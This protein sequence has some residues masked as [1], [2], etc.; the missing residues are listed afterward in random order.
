MKLTHIRATLLRMAVEAGG[1]LP[2]I[3]LAPPERGL[4]TRMKAD[5]LVEWD[6]RV[7]RVTP[8]GR[9]ALTSQEDK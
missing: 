2:A 3:R 4:A 6:R 8:A 5:G 1:E 7:M 9:A